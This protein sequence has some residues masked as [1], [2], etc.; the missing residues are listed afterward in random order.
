MIINLIMPLTDNRMAA[1]LNI[2][3]NDSVYTYKINHGKNNHQL[4]LNA[5]EINNPYS[6]CPNQELHN[7]QLPSQYNH[8]D[9]TRKFFFKENYIFLL[10]AQYVYAL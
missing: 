4:P 3:W 6:A 7:N 10:T 8:K 5:D 2:K 9:Q 1:R